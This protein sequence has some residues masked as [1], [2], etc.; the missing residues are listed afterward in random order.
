MCGKVN[1]FVLE[2]NILYTVFLPFFVICYKACLDITTL[3]FLDIWFIFY[4]FAQ[5]LRK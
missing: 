1:N 4:I 2:S 3:P 5:K